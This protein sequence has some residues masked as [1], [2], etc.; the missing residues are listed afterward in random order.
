MWSLSFSTVPKSPPPVCIHNHLSPVHVLQTIFSRIH[1]NNVIPLDI[2]LPNGCLPSGFRI[3]YMF[4]IFPFMLHVMS[5]ASFWICCIFFSAPF[6]MYKL[7]RQM[8]AAL[9][10]HY[11]RFASVKESNLNS[12]YRFQEWQISLHYTL[13]YQ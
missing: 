8:L 11:Q 3:L 1:I 13:C 9:Y 6:R 4:L 12:T 7:Y 5:V 10:A 2:G